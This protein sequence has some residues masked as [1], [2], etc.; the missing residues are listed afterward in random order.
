MDTEQSTTHKDGITY[1]N[2]DRAKASLLDR[3]CAASSL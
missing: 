2:W 1:V 3:L